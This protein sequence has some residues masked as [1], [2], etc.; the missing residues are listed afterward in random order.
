VWPIIHPSEPC[1]GPSHGTSQETQRAG[2]YARAEA[3]REFDAIKEQLERQLAEAKA[4]AA[5][6]AEAA[7][8]A[9]H[10]EVTEAK[11]AMREEL[12]VL[13]S[14]AHALESQLADRSARLA[15]AEAT[16][17]ARAERAAELEAAAAERAREAAEAHAA[18]SADTIQSQQE[19]RQLNDGFQKELRRVRDEGILLADLARRDAVEP[20]K[21]ELAVL[22]EEVRRCCVAWAK[23]AGCGRNRRAA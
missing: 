22:K 17:A 2:A 21:S 19:L 3:A 10:M 5:A 12:S 15:A 14:K 20:Y 13:Q 8:A 11:S 6:A 9:S 18:R 4:K 7:H 16:A 1:T 23:S